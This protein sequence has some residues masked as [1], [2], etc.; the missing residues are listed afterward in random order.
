MNRI[1]TAS[2]FLIVSLYAHSQTIEKWNIALNMTYYQ[3]Y[4]S[5]KIQAPAMVIYKLYKGGGKYQRTGMDFRTFRGLP[6][7]QYLRSGY[8]KG[9]LCNAEDMAWSY[10]SLKGTFY[11]INAIPQVPE[12]NRGNWARNEKEIRQWS[13]RDS[14]LIICGGME[15]KDGVPKYCYKIV[16]SLSTSKCLQ[17]LIFVNDSTRVIIKSEKLRRSISFKK[18]LRL[19]QSTLMKAD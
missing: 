14:L 15:Y 17:S 10:L 11:Y 16:F 3:S 5:H 19:Y 4:Y 8:D 1:F 12:V 2:C 13:Q 6:H 18:I 9:H 7:Y